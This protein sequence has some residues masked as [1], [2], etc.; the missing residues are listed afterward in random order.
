MSNEIQQSSTAQMTPFK[1]FNETIRSVRMQKY[2]TDVLGAKKD[3]FVTNL[4]SV[5]GNSNALQTCDP[6]SLIFTAT[7]ATAIGL[8]MDQNLGYAALI[9][10]R[11]KD[12]G[13]I[14]A[15]F[16]IMRDGWVELAQRTGRVRLIANEPVH[17]GE[18]VKANKF[19]GE[20]VFDESARKS[21]KVIGYMAYIQLTSGFEKTVYWTVEEC[22]AHA[23][24]YSQTYKKG[25]GLWK[26]NFDAMALKTVIKH[27]IKK[28]A[29]KSVEVVNA[30]QLDQSVSIS[31]TETRFMDNEPDD[32]TQPDLPDGAADAAKAR[33]E[34]VEAQASAMKARAA[35]KAREVNT[36][37]D[38]HT[39]EIFG[40]DA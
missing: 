39:E 5:V 26:D 21:D 36:D 7:K 2:L 4:V 18:L 28:Y 34:E 33:A 11:D 30:V 14:L 23:L 40:G 17:E 15:Q 37:F 32:Q 9:P 3:Q 38:D 12:S 16:Q 1:K 19:T 35:K 24:K 25:Y 27:L 20:F 29:P 31:E 22:K 13:K 6:T 10:Y 8:P